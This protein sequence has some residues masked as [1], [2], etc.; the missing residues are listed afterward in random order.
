MMWFPCG[1]QCGSDTGCCNGCSWQPSGNPEV[2]APIDVTVTTD[3]PG[4]GAHRFWD[5]VTPVACEKPD[6]WRAPVTAPPSS[7]PPSSVPSE[8]N[9]PI[10]SMV[11][12]CNATSARPSKPAAD[13]ANVSTPSHTWGSASDPSTQEPQNSR[14]RIG[15]DATEASEIPVPWQALAAVPT[16]QVKEQEPSLPKPKVTADSAEVPEPPAPYSRCGAGIVCVVVV[17]LTFGAILSVAGMVYKQGLDFADPGCSAQEE[18]D[19]KTCERCGSGTLFFPLGGEWE[20][21]LDEATRAVVYFAML[22]WCFLGVTLVCDQFMNAIEEITS[23]ERVIRIYSSK[24]GEAQLF[25]VH[26]WNGTVAN[27]TLMALGSSAPEILLSCV[28]LM[29]TNG[30]FAGDLGPSTIV[31][32]AAFNLLVIT[33][34]CIS[35]VPDHDTRR[36]DGIEVFITTAVVSVLAY[37]W[38][39]VILQLQTKDL[40]EPWEALVTFVLF[41]ALVL[42]AFVVDKH[43]LP[44]APRALSS[45]CGGGGANGAGGNGDGLGGSKPS[46]RKDLGRFADIPGFTRSESKESSGI[47]VSKALH[48]QSVTRSITGLSLKKPDDTSSSEVT[49][50]YRRRRYSVMQGNCTVAVKVSKIR[51][52]PHAGR[53]TKLNEACEVRVRYYTQ[54]GEARAGIHYRHTEGVLTFTPADVEKAI[55][56]PI[57]SAKGEGG[58]CGDLQRDFEVCLC[59]PEVVWTQ[60]QLVVSESAEQISPRRSMDEHVTYVLGHS[61]ASVI[62]LNTDTAGQLSFASNEVWAK[63]NDEKLCLKVKRSEGCNGAIS[64]HYETVEGNAMEGID[65]RRAEGTLCFEDGEDTSHVDLDIRRR[66]HAEDRRFRVL[67]NNASRGVTF[68]P[69]T[70][71]GA[72]GASCEVVLKGSHRFTVRRIYACVNHRKCVVG[73]RKWREQFPAAC[74]CRGSPEDQATASL[75]DWFFHVL[76]LFWKVAFACVPPPEIAGGWPCFIM[77][78]VGIGFLTAIVGDTASLLGCAMGMPDDVTAI[79]LVALGT[80]LPDTFASMSAAQHDTSADNAIGNVTGSNSVNVFLG[81]GL[82]WTVGA[83]YWTSSGRTQE[84]QEHLYRGVTYQDRWGDVYPD[85]GFIVPAGNLVFSVGVFT[86]AAVLCIT[87]L[88]WRRKALGAELGGSRFQQRRDTL[89]LLV[90]WVLYIAAS[91]AKSLSEQENS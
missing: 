65:F 16:A 36:I 52:P 81:L 28:E 68:D 1:T 56:V 80:S 75:M 91:I 76:T 82:P 49:I 10:F 21:S 53:L 18:R 7:A 61:T 69:D 85:G 34:L 8:N 78:L 47:R 62:V 25:H 11:D 9:M 77:A 55:E 84:W 26:V 3:D 24:S 88:M 57:L 32:S 66:P 39:I 87:L 71:E 73:M 70:D 86:G 4:F 64:C 35:A 63:E 44:G 51:P 83:F 41:P 89:L 46:S 12:H 2:D 29:A 42:A 5:P 40:V 6:R 15:N 33:G 50:G 60:A 74:Y 19:A 30:M 31:G 37:F 22:A 13:S 27:L 38:L 67:L 17:V 90:L 72:T 54:D 20:K 58:S 23:M 59:D 14:P 45:A 48:R 79:T 43:W